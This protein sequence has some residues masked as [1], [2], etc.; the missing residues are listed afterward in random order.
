MLR[1]R[2]SAERK[3]FFFHPPPA[4]AKRTAN[5][6]G[7][8][9]VCWA[10]TDPKMN[11]LWGSEEKAHRNCC[12]DMTCCIH[13]RTDSGGGRNR[14]RRPRFT[15]G[16]EEEEEEE[17]DSSP[18]PSSQLEAGYPDIPGGAI[19]RCGINQTSYLTVVSYGTFLT[20]Y[21]HLETILDCCDF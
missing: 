21:T 5:R 16:N 12:V 8:A 18:I 3:R 20:S 19:C 13:L 2:S 11:A 10:S 14:R 6:N 4:K 7:G 15:L 9:R 17:E 1:E